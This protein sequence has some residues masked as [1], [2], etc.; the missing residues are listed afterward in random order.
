MPSPL[1]DP[2]KLPCG[3]VLPNR[4]SKAAMAEMLA[5]TNEPTSAL[6]DAYE[7]WSDGGWGSILTGNVQV[8]VNHMGSPF[9][10][11]LH[12]EYK[13]SETNNALVAQWKKY[14]DTCQ[15]HGTPAIAQICHPGRQSFRVSGHRG[16]FAPTLAPSAVPIKVGNSY[17]ESLIGCLVWSGPKEMTTQDVERVIR[18]FVD[19]AR[20]MADAGFS[21]VELHGAHGYLI[22][23]FLNG[24]T[25]LRTDAYGGTAEKRTR[26]VLEIL[27]QTRKVVQST[28]A[29]GIKLNSAD[30]SSATFEETMTQIALLAEAGIDFMEISG[31]S[32][33]DPKMMGRGKANPAVAPK[34]ARTAAREAFFLEF[35]KEVRL[36]HPKLVLMLTGGF[37]SRAGAEAAIRDGACDLV[38]IGRPA[39]I[40]PGFPRLLLDESVGDDE[41]S[42]VL[43][44][45]AV[46]WYMQFL[47]LHLVGAGAE[48]TYYSGQIHSLGKG[49]A[50]I[51]PPL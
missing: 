35:S 27:S 22:D 1:A 40:D 36:R 38:G 24:K 13:D 17:L 14:A 4:L 41:A 5:K 47:P 30:H 46:P 25:N 50:T 48:S 33:E 26:F 31:G 8:D 2:V 18:Q 49:I 28:F 32:Y 12:N 7:Q 16:I 43:N 51:A 39:A 29:I 44:N 20:L 9:D 15:K 21:G 11:A 34:S 6:V 45:V 23:Q 3:L 42:M 19:T 37:R 10:P